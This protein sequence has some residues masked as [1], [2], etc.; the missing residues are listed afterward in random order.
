V[1]ARVLLSLSVSSC[2]RQAFNG[3]R[4]TVS[5]VEAEPGAEEEG[6]TDEGRAVHRQHDAF[7]ELPVPQHGAREHIKLRCAAIA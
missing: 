3:D 2:S 4:S 6:H 5:D 7:T 1:A